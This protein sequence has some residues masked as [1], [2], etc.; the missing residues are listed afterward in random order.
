MS[1]WW[2]AAGHGPGHHGVP[3]PRRH[4]RP[5]TANVIFGPRRLLSFGGKKKEANAAATEPDPAHRAAR[6]RASLRSSATRF[7][8]G[9]S[10]RPA[11]PA[12]CC[13]DGGGRGFYGVVAISAWRLAGERRSSTT[14]WTRVIRAAGHPSSANERAGRAGGAG[15]GGGW[16]THTS[17]H[18]PPGHP[19]DAAHTTFVRVPAAA[20]GGRDDR[21]RG[22]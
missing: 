10:V 13:R 6:R 9:R 12:G 15:E 18:T 3:G 5:S 11:G 14:W 17:P 22:V 2:F 20:R 4:L 8:P 19:D 21:R 7:G 1:L 16:G